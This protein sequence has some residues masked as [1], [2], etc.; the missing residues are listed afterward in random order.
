MRCFLMNHNNKNWYY[1]YL[2]SF[3]SIILITISFARTKRS[4][5]GGKGRSSN[6]G[7]TI[8][9][10]IPEYRDVDYEFLLEQTSD[11]LLFSAEPS[12]SGGLKFHFH[13]DKIK[14]ARKHSVGKLLLTIGGGGRSNYFYT[15]S[16][17]E[18]LRESFISTLYETMKKY[19]LQGVDYDWEQPQN[20]E[21]VKAYSQLIV[22]TAELFKPKKLLLSVALHP[23][24]DLLPAAKK[25]IDRIHLM[26]YDYG[27]RHSTL[28][29][30]KQHVEDMLKKGFLREQIILGIPGY[31]RNIKN[32]GEVKTYSELVNAKNDNDEENDIYN[33]IYFNNLKTIKKKIRYAIKQGLGGVF[34]WEAGHD[35]NVEKKSILYNIKQYIIK[36]KISFD[37]YNI[38][39]DT[40]KR[41]NDNDEEK[42][43]SI[44]RNRGSSSS[45]SR[46]RRR[47]IAVDE[48]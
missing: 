31:G 9:T 7:F 23:W 27:E 12:S 28:K 21:E 20:Y 33:N 3:I 35:S 4:K 1:F 6:V 46:R 47:R 43:G 36:K 30:A 15:I 44:T 5:Y 40:E 25:V 19:N 38:H 14:T 11:L 42:V 32:P 48:L 22:E 17:E 34:L 37:M 45:S 26:S 39:D 24:N 16:K 41:I 2:F 13:D 18:K 29:N 8:S 10:Y